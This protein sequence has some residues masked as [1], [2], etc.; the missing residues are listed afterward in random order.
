MQEV[1]PVS[2]APE[3]ALSQFALRGELAMGPSGKVLLA[4]HTPSNTTVVIKEVPILLQQGQ[5]AEVL[6]QLST[7]YNSAHPNI[8]GFHGVTYS[9]QGGSGG[10]IYL[11]LE[12]CEVGSLLDVY[13]RAGA[14]PEDVLGVIAGHVLQGLTYLHRV[15]YQ[16][17][18]D[19]KPSNILINLRGQAKITDF[20]MSANLVSTLDKKQTWLGNV[21]YMSP[22]R[23][24]GLGYAC[25]SDVWG[26][27]IMLAECALGRYPYESQESFYDLLNVIVASPAPTLPAEQFSP[28]FHDFLAKCL[29]K[30][31]ETR[32][33]ADE[34]LQ[35][36]FV[37][38]HHG[39]DISRWAAQVAPQS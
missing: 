20:G 10:C 14:I 39:K 4:T 16:V 17:H 21:T 9:D 27:G 8:C 29:D 12:Y 11:G 15:R 32:A 18:R 23:I 30:Q 35:H 36:P 28:Q 3:L 33:S 13:K 37:L 2:A 6:Q 26:F 7:L 34:L 31:G 5:Q 25:K 24:S 22:E 38:G 1:D 19:I